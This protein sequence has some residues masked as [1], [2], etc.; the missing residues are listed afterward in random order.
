MVDFFFL[1]ANNYMSLDVICPLCMEWEDSKLFKN[2]LK[3]TEF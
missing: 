2:Q 3:E 1:E